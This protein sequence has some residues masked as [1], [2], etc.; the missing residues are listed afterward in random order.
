MSPLYAIL[1][2]VHASAGLELVL[3]QPDYD[4]SLRGAL[5][6]HSIENLTL[7]S[8]NGPT[9]LNLRDC[10]SCDTDVRME[11]II[12]RPGSTC[13]FPVFGWED[14]KRYVRL[15][16][17]GRQLEILQVIK[18][19]HRPGNN[20]MDLF[21]VNM[22]NCEF[23]K[24]ET[25]RGY[26]YFAAGGAFIVFEPENTEYLEIFSLNG[27]KECG[28]RVCRRKFDLAS[29]EIGMPMK[30]PLLDDQFQGWQLTFLA[31]SSGKGYFAIVRSAEAR[32]KLLSV[33]ADG[34]LINSSDDSAESKVHLLKM[35]TDHGAFGFC[36]TLDDEQEEV[37]CMQLDDSLRVLANATRDV[38]YRPSFLAVHN[39]PASGGLLLLVVRCDVTSDCREHQM[40]IIKL[41]SDGAVSQPYAD[42]K[43]EGC[44]P[45]NQQQFHFYEDNEQICVFYAC[46]LSVEEGNTQMT[47]RYRCF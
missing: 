20:S 27:E 47:V 45:S 18:I 25:L 6:E 38:G 24:T 23:T 43:D 5:E 1:A 28:T 17:S 7:L 39:L 19:F 31:A 11:A 4:N 16:S 26:D 3:K 44:A 8:S 46:D 36:Y 32:I 12:E 29:R 14:A 41:D 9:K 30:F 42:F 37:H 21:V 33:N 40:Q 35:S 13:S 22:A 2:V 15:F 34:E 10:Q